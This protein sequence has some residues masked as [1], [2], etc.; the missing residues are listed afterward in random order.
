MRTEL[1]I[2]DNTVYEVDLDCMYKS[3]KNNNQVSNYETKIF[4]INNIEEFVEDKEK[5]FAMSKDD[6]WNRKKEGEIN[7]LIVILI[8]YMFK[9]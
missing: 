2:D 6:R 4:S 1:V 7:L 3:K 8:I 5:V 9:V